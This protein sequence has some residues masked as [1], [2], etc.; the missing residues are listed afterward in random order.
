MVFRG[1]LA[2]W[3]LESLMGLEDNA[4]YQA[5]SATCYVGYRV[6]SVNGLQFFFFYLTEKKQQGLNVNITLIRALHNA[7][8]FL[9]F[10]PHHLACLVCSWHNCPWPYQEQWWICSYPSFTAVIKHRL[11]SQEQEH[12]SVLHNA[13]A[14]VWLSKIHKSIPPSSLSGC[15]FCSVC[16]VPSFR[17]FSIYVQKFWTKLFQFWLFFILFTKQRARQ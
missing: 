14:R 5:Q 8:F 6:P 1:L 3:R 4:G 17:D 7:V 10:A 2:V 9:H 13:K 12:V 11:A 16:S 15:R